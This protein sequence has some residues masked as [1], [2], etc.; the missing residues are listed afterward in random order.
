MTDPQS[1]ESPPPPQ[2]DA[3]TE[4]RRIRKLG[5]LLAVL[6]GLL[7]IVLILYLYPL[8]RAK[9]FSVAGSRPIT[10]RGDL[11]NYE[12]TTISLFK[13]ASPSVVFITVA[14]PKA[15]NIRPEI[16][17]SGPET[18]SGSGFIWDAQG[19]VVTNYHVLQQANAAHVILSDQTIYDAEFVGMD[20]DHDLA[21]LKINVPVTTRL[22]PIPL[23]SI[24]DLQVGQS[25]FAIGNPFGLD[26]TITGGIISAL[27]RTIRSIGGAPIDGVIQTDAAI[28]PGNSGGPL[29]DSAGR[30]IGVSTAMVSST[31]TNSGIGFAIPVDTTN[32]VVP[33][34]IAKGRYQPAR[35]GIHPLVL[36]PQVQLPQGVQGVPVGAVEPGSPAEKAGLTAA[37]IIPAQ[38][39]GLRGRNAFPSRAQLG[40]IITQLNDRP[41]RSPSDLY[42]A[43][44]RISPGDTVELMIWNSGS[45]RNV[46]IKTY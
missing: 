24:D 44:D 6:T 45:I 15:F 38:S 37:T 36:N 34:I 33:Q 16:R 20:P 11:M 21:V 29:L 32:R 3:A 4:L 7:I 1:P 41:I 10:P 8:I 17:D 30:L 46:R 27:N 39:R 23:G 42:T 25:V 19:H 12:K 40:D 9:Y 28:N 5:R 26:Q 2:P 35:I 43:L 18:G 31:G 14:Q 22:V 13:Q